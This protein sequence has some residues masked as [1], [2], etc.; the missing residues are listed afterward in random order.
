M[1]MA[2]WQDVLGDGLAVTLE[3]PVA[4]SERLP[5]SGDVAARLLDAIAALEADSS[6]RSNEELPPPELTRLELKLDLLMDLV[7]TLL[8]DQVPRCV[9][10]KLSGE[11][12]VI[13]AGVLPIECTRLAIYPCHWLAQPLILELNPFI[14]RDQHCGATWYSPDYGLREVLQR[15]VF[16]LHRR[17]VA[18][19][20]LQSDL[21]DSDLIRATA[22]TFASTSKNFPPL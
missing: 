6:S 20:R 16:R 22:S 7:M 5:T 8:A 12:I 14:Q 15:W 3:L 11:G 4:A 17:D 18:R 10:I 19:R 13:P 21:Q 2:N 9:E 1:T